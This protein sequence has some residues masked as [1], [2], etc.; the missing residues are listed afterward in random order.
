MNWAFSRGW[1]Y[2]NSSPDYIFSVYPRT[3]ILN[4]GIS[5]MTQFIYDSSK[6]PPRYLYYSER[7]YQ[8]EF[9]SRTSTLRSQTLQCC[10][11][12]LDHR[13][14]TTTVPTPSACFTSGTSTIVW[15]ALELL[16][17]GLWTIG[18]KPLSEHFERENHDRACIVFRAGSL[19][20]HTY[21]LEHSW[22]D[23]FWLTSGSSFRESIGFPGP[24]YTCSMQEGLQISIILRLILTYFSNSDLSVKG[25]RVGPPNDS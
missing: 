23:N 20:R 12:L 15:G 19:F 4:C 16:A 7:S 10:K 3:D 24:F 11:S 13:T 1:F 14:K 8:K 9:S 5:R 22:V 18:H 25:Y 21:V 17:S 6:S 2:W